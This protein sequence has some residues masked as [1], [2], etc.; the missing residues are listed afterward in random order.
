MKHEQLID[1]VEQLTLPEKI[2]QLQQ[3]T[4]DFFIDRETAITG[5]MKEYGLDENLLHQAGSVLGLSGAAD[6]IE[7][8]KNYIEKSRLGIPLLFMADIIHGYR[9]IFPI[10]LGLACSWNPELVEKTAQVAAKESAVSGLHVTFSPMVDLVRDPRWGRVMES[11]GEDPYL[12]QLYGKAFVNGYQGKDLTNDHERIAACVKHF[13]GY[14]APEGGREY[15]TVDIS[16]W[17]FR[18]FYLPAYAEAIQAGSKLVMTAFN[19]LEGI[20][21]TAN[22]KLMRDILRKELKFNG[23]LISDWAAIKELI[24]HGVAADEAEAA[25]LAIEA[26]VDIEM[27]TFCYHHF[28]QE[29][30]E[31]GLIEQGLIDEAV[32]RILELKNDLGLFENPYRGADEQKE[33][34]VVYSEE[35]QQ[36]ALKAAEESIVLL[37]NNGSL[38]LKI[39]DKIAV[40]GPVANSTD[41]LGNWSWKGDRSETQTLTSALSIYYPH[42]LEAQGCGVLDGSS[43]QL[44]EALEIAKNADKIILALGESAD[45]VGEGASVTNLQLPECQLNLLNEISKLNKTIVLVLINGRPLDLSDVSEKCDAILEAWFPGSKGA[46]AVANILV[47]NTVPQGKLTMSFPRNIG[48][49]PVYYNAFNTGRP[50]E[51]LGTE[52]RYI[53][54]YV[55]VPNTPLFPFGFGLSYTSFDY[56]DLQLSSKEMKMENGEITASVTIR[57]TGNHDGVETIQWYIRDLVGK[58]VR[59]VKELKGFEKIHLKKNESK[60]ITFTI[61]TDQL[62]YIHSDFKKT[63][64]PGEFILM[65]GGDSENILQERLSLVL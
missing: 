52:G 3:L 7:V 57:N 15:N 53:S 39:E 13:A 1:L 60:Q 4:G 29:L 46:E 40:I 14:G 17:E 54:K 59:P 44:E 49:I 62:T 34:E 2:G 18:D 58:V 27:M 20:P 64:E 56:Q 9:T 47:G 30:V 28:L 32:L 26:G 22:K 25:E 45:M 10:P 35:H 55:D 12:N 5:P 42:L 31:E 38:P 23:V 11:T 24:P 63:I 37:K 36:I 19:I 43:T 16:E 50:T 65:V 8:Q 41:L 21:A 6:L 48:Q 51:L 33:A 61:T